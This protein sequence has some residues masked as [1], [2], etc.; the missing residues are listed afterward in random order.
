MRASRVD[1]FGHAVTEIQ[2]PSS[3]AVCGRL[4]KMVT[5]LACMSLRPEAIKEVELAIGEALSN[6]VKYG[7]GSRICVRVEA[8]PWRELTVEFDYPG[9]SFDTRVTRPRNP[10]SSQGGYGR[11]IIHA[12]TDGM[13]YSFRDGRTTLRLT[14]KDDL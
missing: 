9:R 7:S 12:V 6:A 14:K 10:E 3:A 2:I 4:R 1:P 11:Y 8:F 13:E 5:R